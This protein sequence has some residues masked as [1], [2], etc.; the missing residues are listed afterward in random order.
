MEDVVTKMEKVK[1]IARHDG[2]SFVGEG[3]DD[4]ESLLGGHV[5]GKSEES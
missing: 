3:P 1:L 2:L 5:D 4:E